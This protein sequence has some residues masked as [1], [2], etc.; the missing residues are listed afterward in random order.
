MR[1]RFQITPAIADRFKE[2]ICV[3]VDTDF[4]YIQVVEPRELFLDPL[5]YELNNETIV[6]YIELFFKSKKHK[7]E[8]LFGT[9]DEIT[10]L[11]HQASLEKVSQKKIES[12]MKKELS[13]VGMTKSESEVVRQTMKQGLLNIQPFSISLEQSGPYIVV[14]DVQLSETKRQFERL[15]EAIITKTKR[16]KQQATRPSKRQ[17]TFLT[18]FQSS[19]DEEE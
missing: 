14:S 11:A 13:K 6:R 8:Y 7:V 19:D 3:R 10:Q 17:K 2:V 4:T 12:I 18:I 15:V 1:Q 16:I 5:G 9:Y